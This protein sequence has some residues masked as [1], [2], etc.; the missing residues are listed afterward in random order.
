MILVDILNNLKE[1]GLTPL[2][3]LPPALRAELIRNLATIA[4]YLPNDI[5]VILL[6]DFLVTTEDLPPNMIGV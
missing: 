2:Y 4:E 5:K 1:K 6:K 3:A